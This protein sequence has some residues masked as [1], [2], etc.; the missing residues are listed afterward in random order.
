MASD[1]SPTWRAWL[2]ERLRLAWAQPR[3]EEPQPPCCAVCLEPISEPSQL[4]SQHCEHRF[5]TQCLQRW[6]AQGVVSDNG[7]PTCRRRGGTETLPS[8]LSEEEPAPSGRAAWLWSWLTLAMVPWPTSRSTTPQWDPARGIGDW[9]ARLA[10][11]H[12]ADDAEADAESS[13]EDDEDSVADDAED[14]EEQFAEGAAGGC[15]WCAVKDAEHDCPHCG[16][17]G[18]GLMAECSC[19]DGFHCG[20]DDD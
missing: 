6:Q 4:G 20:G 8:E 2:L 17:G 11:L 18:F 12:A 14:Y 7:C 3:A 10:A 15:Q 13:E 5:H 19:P 16:E 1:A 9:E